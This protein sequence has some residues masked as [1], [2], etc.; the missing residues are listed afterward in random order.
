MKSLADAAGV[1]KPVLY[2]HFTSKHELYLELLRDVGSRLREAIALALAEAATAHERVEAGFHA[3]FTFFSKEPYAFEVLFGDSARKDEAFATE[4][5][6][7]EAAVAE[8]IAAL[9]TIEGLSDDDRRVLAFGIVGLAEGASRFWMMRG[10]DLDPA[11]LAT[12]VAD[13]MWYG[14]RG[15]VR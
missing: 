1:T 14:L 12:Q 8:N 2:Q 15:R 5:H 11:T 3:Y 9:I 10:F 6:A 4:S 7:V 13:L